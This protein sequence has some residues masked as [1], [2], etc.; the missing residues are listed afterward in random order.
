MR[1]WQKVAAYGTGLVVVLAAALWV[2]GVVGPVETDD[3]AHDSSGH[4][5]VRLQPADSGHDHGS[6]D[7]KHGASRASSVHTLALDSGV[8]DAGRAQ[9]GFRVLDGSGEPVTSYDVQHEKELHLIA[10]RRDLAAFRHVHPRLDPATGRWSVPV[11]LEPGSWRLYADFV[12]AGGDPALAEAEL[13]VA[14]DYRPE[15]LG[16]DTDTARVDDYE[17]HLERDPETSMATFHVT[18]GGVEV[19]ALEPYLGAYGHLVAIGADDLD[20]VHVHPEEG[21]PGPEVAFHVE[22]PDAGR[23]RLFLDF[24]HDGVVRTADFTVTVGD[25]AAPAP[26]DHEEDGHGH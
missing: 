15:P 17:V 14:G 24:R 20:Y 5:R 16:G 12:P 22:L 26:D 6:G 18:R 19:E 3:T 23:Y 1:A 21:E 9:L 4:D 2:G 10:V 8:V 7:D 11:D 13:Q 25:G